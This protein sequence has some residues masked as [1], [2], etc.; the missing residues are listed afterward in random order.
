MAKLLTLLALVAVFATVSAEVYFEEKFDGASRF[1]HRSIN[2]TR[3]LSDCFVSVFLLLF[4]LRVVCF[5]E[6]P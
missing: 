3:S 5:L 6:P 1:L 2:K 4:F